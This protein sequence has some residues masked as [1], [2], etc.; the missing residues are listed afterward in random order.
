MVM[1]TSCSAESRMLRLRSS[2]ANHCF[3]KTDTSCSARTSAEQHIVR[4]WE[5]LVGRGRGI[6]HWLNKYTS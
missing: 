5:V 1:L 6:T 4:N 3:L 2:L